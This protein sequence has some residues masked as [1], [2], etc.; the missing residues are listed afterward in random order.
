MNIDFPYRIAR[1]GRTATVDDAGHVRDMIEL[2][3]FTQPGERVMRPDFG[4]GLLQFV[5]APNSLEMAAALQLTVQ[6][7]LNQHLGDL[8]QVRDLRVETVDAELRVTL[9]Y[10]LRTTGE[11]RADTFVRSTP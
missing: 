11:E 2:L 5:F 3:L 4:S 10:M 7:A 9:A 6:A 1:D 8:I